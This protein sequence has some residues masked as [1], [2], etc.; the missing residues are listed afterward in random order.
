MANIASYAYSRQNEASRNII[1]QQRKHVDSFS[2][3]KGIITI[4]LTAVLDTPLQHL[5]T[6]FE[7]SVKTDRGY[8]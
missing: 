5:L 2:F 1:R 3:N 8:E 4:S 7:T 6:Q